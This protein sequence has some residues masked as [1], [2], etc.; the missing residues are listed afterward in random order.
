MYLKD[1]YWFHFTIPPLNDT[2]SQFTDCI[3]WRE[4]HGILCVF[5][6]STGIKYFM[7]TSGKQNCDSVC[8][9][10]GLQCAGTGQSFPNSSALSIFESLGIT[11]DTN[12][13]TD[14]YF[15]KDQPNYIS[16]SPPSKDLQWAG[17]CTGFKAIPSTIDC[18]TANNDNVRR[19]C[20]CK[21]PSGGC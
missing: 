15:Y 16:A 11:C 1:Q 9:S 17:R 19:L 21:N 20:P 18:Y 14:Y 2:K 8:A 7:A 12:N 6:T 10:F 5:C 13:Y 4:K 3:S